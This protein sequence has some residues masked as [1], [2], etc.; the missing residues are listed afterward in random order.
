[1]QVIR[2]MVHWIQL[3][4]HLLPADQREHMVFGSSRLL[5]VAQDFYRL[6]GW[7]RFRRLDA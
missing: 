1:L 4:A 3:W 6:A 5:T 2:M 7:Q